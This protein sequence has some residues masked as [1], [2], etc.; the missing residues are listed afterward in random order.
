[1]VCRPL[2]HEE[3]PG[4]TRTLYR[5]PLSFAE[6]THSLSTPFF[7]T[8]FPMIYTGLSVGP[9]FKESAKEEEEEKEGGESGSRNSGIEEQ[10]EVSLSQIFTLSRYTYPPWNV[11][12][13]FLLAIGCSRRPLLVQSYRKAQPSFRF[14]TEAAFGRPIIGKER[15]KEGCQEEEE[16]NSDKGA[17]ETERKKLAASVYLR[18]YFRP[19]FTRQWF[20]PRTDKNYSNDW[21]RCKFHPGIPLPP[22]W[23]PWLARHNHHGCSPFFRWNFDIY[24]EKL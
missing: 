4:K 13:S 20:Q 21:S 6:S 10:D 16:F 1:M 24:Y 5:F 3:G 19:S 22:C 17:R 23:L 11:T 2:I 14:E 15:E 9:G 12:P 18:P 8:S 7:L